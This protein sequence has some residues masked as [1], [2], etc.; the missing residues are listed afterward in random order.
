MAGKNLVIIFFKCG[1]SCYFGL[2]FPLRYLL[3]QS[4]SSEKKLVKPLKDCFF[5]PICTKKGSLWAKPKMKNNFFFAEIA[6]ADQQLSESF[7]LSKY[8]IICFD[9][10]T[11]W[12]FFYFER[13]GVFC[14]KSVKLK[15]L[16][17]VGK[18]LGMSWSP[19]Q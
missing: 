17:P 1:I 10:V 14:Q 8:H 19:I 7:I 3:L 11:L 18:T 5:S 15:Q 16:S 13:C 9:W 12:I 6:K 2:Q 4:S